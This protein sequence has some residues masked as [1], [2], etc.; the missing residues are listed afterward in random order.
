[1]PYIQHYTP[2]PKKQTDFTNKHQNSEITL[3]NVSFNPVF[4]MRP[5]NQKYNTLR[6]TVHFKFCIQ[7]LG[8]MEPQ[9]L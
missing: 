3:R 2:P 7:I 8:G 9:M 4:I 6:F 5:T 1:M